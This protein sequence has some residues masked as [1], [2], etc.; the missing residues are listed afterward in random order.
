MMLCETYIVDRASDTLI[1][2]ITPTEELSTKN[3]KEKEDLIIRRN[4]IFAKLETSA[5]SLAPEKQ[6][7]LKTHLHTIRTFFGPQ[8]MFDNPS[9]SFGFLTIRLDNMI[10]SQ[11][12]TS[13]RTDSKDVTQE[14]LKQKIL[15][16]AFAKAAKQSPTV[17]ERLINFLTVLDINVIT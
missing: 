12:L 4:R 15:A 7:T 10:C 6:T 3:Q 8:E 9:C 2:L 13:L 17:Q 16:T 11:I 14:E 1:L 5:A